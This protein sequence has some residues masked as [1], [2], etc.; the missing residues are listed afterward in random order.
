MRCKTNDCV[1][2]VYKHRLYPCE[3]V[4]IVD[5]VKIKPVYFTE[6]LPYKT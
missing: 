5:E 2:Q 4:T 1:L 3:T 6:S